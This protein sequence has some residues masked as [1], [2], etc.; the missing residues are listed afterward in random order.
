MCAE[1]P[2]SAAVISVKAFCPSQNCTNVVYSQKKKKHSKTYI[3]RSGFKSKR[4][5]ARDAQ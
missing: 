3:G 1:C 5:D 2:V 4:E